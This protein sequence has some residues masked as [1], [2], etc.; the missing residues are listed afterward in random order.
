MGRRGTGF[1]DMRPLAVPLWAGCRGCG[2]RDSCRDA[3]L[4]FRGLPEAQKAL[5]LTPSPELVS[6]AGVD[7]LWLF[8]VAGSEVG[9]E[10]VDS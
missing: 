5:W 6:L 4:D 3:P 10:I 1:N 2:L 9:N 8:V 7:G